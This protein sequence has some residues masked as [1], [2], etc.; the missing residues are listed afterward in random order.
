MTVHSLVV[1]S[2]LDHSPNAVD[3]PLKGG[4]RL[5]IIPSV[6][7]LPRARKYHFAAYC[8]AESLL[9]VWQ[10]DVA[11]LV[12]HAERIENDLMEMAWEADQEDSETKSMLGG[13][14]AEVD[15]ESGRVKPQ[16]R[17]TK[18]YNTFLVSITLVIIVVV[19]GAGFRQLAIE[20]AVDHSYLRLA[21][22]ALT[23]IQIFFTLVL[24]PRVVSQN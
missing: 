3:I 2:Y 21:F 9:V 13:P 16:E 8:T 24:E 19:L 4:L 7:D 23:P 17:R 14:V 18:L 10:D 11:K 20:I 15:E 22:G 5:Q 1:N 6:A 12:G